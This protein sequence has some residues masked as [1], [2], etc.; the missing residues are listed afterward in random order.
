[1]PNNDLLLELTAHINEYGVWINKEFELNE[2]DEDDIFPI[3]VMR[4]TIHK[5]LE[6]LQKRSISFDASTLR[7]LDKK[8]QSYLQ[9][10]KDSDYIFSV[11][12]DDEPKSNWWWWIDQLDTLTD[13]EKTTL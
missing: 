12:R 11:N 7:T 8:W 1:M 10:H 5:I 4:E 6:E 3:V 9:N 2:S 13:E